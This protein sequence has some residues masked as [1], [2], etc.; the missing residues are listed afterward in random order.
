MIPLFLSI[1]EEAVSNWTI[2]SRASLFKTIPRLFFHS[3]L[4]SIYLFG[5]VNSILRIPAARID[6]FYDFSLNAL[7]WCD[8]SMNEFLC[9]GSLVCTVEQFH[10]KKIRRSLVYTGV[11]EKYCNVFSIT[12]NIVLLFCVFEYSWPLTQ[13]GSKNTK[14]AKKNVFIGLLKNSLDFII[15]FVFLNSCFFE[16]VQ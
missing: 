13:G 9:W 4:V 16:K 11:K 8:S 12:K 15:W 6:D 3:F 7:S 10:I 1:G 14:I 5:V 2:A